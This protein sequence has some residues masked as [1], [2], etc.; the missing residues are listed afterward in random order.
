[1]TTAA[2]ATA[3]HLDRTSTP[4]DRLAAMRARVAADLAAA[5]AYRAMTR[6]ADPDAWQA[7]ALA[8]LERA[9]AD[10]QVPDLA[11]VVDRA[12][13]AYP[14]HRANLARAARRDDDRAAADAGQ[15][16]T[17][18]NRTDRLARVAG[19][20][21]PAGPAVV[22]RVMARR[23]L[24]DRADRRPLAADLAD[25]C[26]ALDLDHLA[27]LAADHLAALDLDRHPVTRAAALDLDRRATAARALADHRAAPGQA[28][29]AAAAAMA[30]MVADLDHLTADRARHHLAD[31]DHR[32]TARTADHLA[33]MLAAMAADGPVVR[34][35]HDP[36]GCTR[37]NC[38][39]CQRGQVGPLTRPPTRK[40]P[41]RTRR[42]SGQFRAP[43]EITLAA[44]AQMG[45]GIGSRDGQTM[46]IREQELLSMADR[47]RAMGASGAPGGRSIPPRAAIVGTRATALAD[48]AGRAVV[49]APG[50][51]GTAV[52]WQELAAATGW[53][54]R[55]PMGTVRTMVAAAALATAPGADA[56]ADRLADL[57]RAA[58]V[59]AADLATAWH[60][61]DHLAGPTPA[62]LARTR[63]ADRARAAALPAPVDL[64]R[65]AT[66]AR[67]PV[68]LTTAGVPAPWLARRR[69]AAARLADHL[70]A[71]AT[72]PDRAARLAAL[73]SAVVR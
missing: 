43:Q 7:S 54:G 70:A 55:V 29:R 17:R 1:M 36:A 24:A 57:A 38:Q 11:T 41:G 47:T 23:D 72:A 20:F 69:L 26:T 31:L 40:A 49:P 66:L 14:G 10:G 64:A 34:A 50:Q 15:V 5:A 44:P 60:D 63:A 22:R 9:A 37:V 27:D 32:A 67:R 12:A 65:G 53:A 6:S 62:R 8:E 2:T 39:R 45:K 56:M 25:A 3:P 28:W 13:A 73:A 61:L 58:G 16:V 48:L 71:R 35:D 21:H 52:A 18:E 59:G 51:R 30:P 68:D 42:P 19:Q 4:S 46:V 33:A